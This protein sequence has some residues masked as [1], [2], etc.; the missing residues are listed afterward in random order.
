MDI[1]EAVHCSLL[2]VAL[3]VPS[4]IAWGQAQDVPLAD[5]AAANT[6]EL[7]EIVVVGVRASL[8][9]SRDIKREAGVVQDSIVA[10]DLGRFPDANVAA[11]CRTCPASRC[12]APVA[13]KASTSTCAASVPNTASS[14]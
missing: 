5:G 8:E 14:R 12:N 2:S 6:A 1:R 7:E 4:G 13:A 9:Q 10:E 11:R 3:G